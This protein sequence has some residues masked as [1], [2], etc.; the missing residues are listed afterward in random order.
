MKTSTTFD[1]DE[2]GGTVATVVSAD[3]NGL[4]SATFLSEADAYAHSEAL[5]SM[6]ITSFVICVTQATDGSTV[7]DVEDPE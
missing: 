2:C 5:Q 3:E 4:S 1:L 6:G 7:V